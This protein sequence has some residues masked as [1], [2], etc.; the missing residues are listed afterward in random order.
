MRSFRSAASAMAH[1]PKS[2]ISTPVPRTSITNSPSANP[3]AR[4][5]LRAT[6]FE[7]MRWPCRTHV[8][9]RD[10]RLAL[11]EPDRLDLTSTEDKDKSRSS[12]PTLEPAAD[13]NKPAG[14]GGEPPGTQTQVTLSAPRAA[15]LPAGV[16]FGRDSDSAM[17]LPIA[18]LSSDRM[19]TRAMPCLGCAPGPPWLTEATGTS[20]PAL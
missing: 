10:G 15:T 7:S 5:G 12:A 4:V 17:A 14:P 11:A 2:P 16:H 20:A 8:A 19:A 13:H 6:P 3:Q 18:R 1:I 9:F